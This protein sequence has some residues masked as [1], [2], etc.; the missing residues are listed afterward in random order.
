MISKQTIERN[1]EWS[2][3]N[4][5]EKKGLLKLQKRIRRDEIAI[6]KTDKSGKIAAI[7]KEDYLNMRLAAIENDKKLERKEIRK[8]EQKINDHTRM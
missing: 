5:N 6:L 8:I 2:N 4:K 1:Q 3:L 7:K